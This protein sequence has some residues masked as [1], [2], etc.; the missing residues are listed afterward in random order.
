MGETHEIAYVDLPP[1]CAQP[2]GKPLSATMFKRSYLTQKWAKLFETCTVGRIFSMRV[3]RIHKSSFCESLVFTN[4]SGKPEPPCQAT[5]IE[6]GSPHEAICAGFVDK[7]LP[8]LHSYL[9]P[10]LI[11][12]VCHAWG[13]CGW[14][15][16]IPMHFKY[17]R[18]RDASLT[19]KLVLAPPLSQSPSHIY[20]VHGLSK[21]ASC[22]FLLACFQK[23]SPVPAA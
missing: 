9:F 17:H 21:P 11:P 7:C 14:H 18:Q 6:F 5:P 4:Y 12:D 22:A 3:E 2:K 10:N 16:H 19:A 13:G 23:T 1:I 15:K 20:S 8:I